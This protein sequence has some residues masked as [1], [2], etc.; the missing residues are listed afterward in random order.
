[1][2]S[3]GGARGAAHIGVIKILE[4]Y[5]IPIDCIAG[6][7]MGALIGGAYATGMTVD[8]MEAIMKMMSVE[9]LFRETPPRQQLTMRAKLDDYHNYIGPELAVEKGAVKLPM[10][11]VSGVK[12]EAVLRR[13]AQVTGYHRFD[14]FPIP[15][16]AVAT[17]LVTGKKV[18]FEKGELAD[19]MRASMSVPGAIAPVESGEMLLV[20]GMLTANL[21]VEVARAM[22]A[23]VIIAVNVGTPLL[24][25]AQ[26][27]GVLGVTGQMLSILTEQNVKVSLAALRPGDILISPELG[28]YSTADF[29]RLPGIVPLGEAAAQN[30][31]AQLAALSIPTEEYAALRRSQTRPVAADAR[32]LDAVWV[33]PLVK[34]NPQSVLLAMKTRTGVAVDQITLDA[35][36]RRVYGSGDFGHV[37]Y[38]F[39]EDTGRRVLVVEAVEKSTSRDTLRFGLGLSSDFNGDA[40]YNLVGSYSKNWLNERGGEWR[41]DF[42]IGRTSSIRSEIYQPFD[43]SNR[44]FIAPAVEAQRRTNY[45]YQGDHRVA[46]YVLSYRRGTL[47]LGAPIGNL[48]EVRAGVVRGVIEPRLDTGAESLSP[49]ASK[50]AQGAFTARLV[51]D[52]LDSLNFPRAGWQG[53]ATIFQSNSVLGAHDTYTRWEVNGSFVRSFGENTFNLAIKAGGAIGSNALP[54]YDQFQWGGF[55]QQSG[56]RTGQLYGQNVTFGRL[57]YYRRLLKGGLFDG[58][59]GGV[60]LEAGKVGRPLVPDSPEGLLKSASIFVG[61]DSPLGPVYFAYGRSTSGSGSFYFYLGRPF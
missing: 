25:R 57:I 60:S 22:G 39:L 47:D 38:S 55:L 19:V 17:D 27:N 18:I 7:S 59:Y 31:A 26:I 45:L 36:I 61:A 34:V 2:L 9:L 11:A 10:G 43:V 32:P 15:F 12:L 54:R 48:G 5:R 8:Q 46:S 44:F 40:F 24:K 50:I 21:P 51:F 33:A 56:Y 49:G 35:D 4:Q 58:A 37:G 14:D 1:M 53:G 13:I 42:Q 52:Q 3:G 6:T 30:A 28:D 23:D 20:D 29:D 16:R 41:T